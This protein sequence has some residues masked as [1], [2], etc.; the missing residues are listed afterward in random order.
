MY[1]IL[2]YKCLFFPGK[3]IVGYVFAP[4]T[5]ILIV[6]EIGLRLVNAAVPFDG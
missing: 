6:A 2:T 1:N 4:V 3:N 5:M